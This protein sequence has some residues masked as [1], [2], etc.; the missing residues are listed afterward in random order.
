MSIN[1]FQRSQSGCWT[2]ALQYAIYFKEAIQA[3]AVLTIFLGFVF[4]N[5]PLG[6]LHQMNPPSQMHLWSLPTFPVL[7]YSITLDYHWQMFYST[8]FALYC[9]SH[10]RKKERTL[11]GVRLL[12]LLFLCFISSHYDANYVIGSPWMFAEWCLRFCQTCSRLCGKHKVGDKWSSVLIGVSYHCSL[13]ASQNLL[14]ACESSTEHFSENDIHCPV[15][16]LSSLYYP[17]TILIVEWTAVRSSK[18]TD[19]F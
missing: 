14:H 13:L 1:I 17:R 2:S 9:Q 16:Y 6:Q 7:I 3:M 8:D 12:S 10:S 5:M 19:A 18:S 15:S 11:M 4:Q